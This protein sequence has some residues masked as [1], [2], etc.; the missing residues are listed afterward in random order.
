MHPEIEAP[1]LLVFIYCV[2][3]Y[4]SGSLFMNV[5]GMAVDASLQCFIATE[6]MKLDNNIIPA[7][8]RS[9]VDSQKDEKS[10]GCCGCC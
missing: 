6:E 9:F 1:W 2:I 5:F 8:L 7:P 3:G 4:F 10:G